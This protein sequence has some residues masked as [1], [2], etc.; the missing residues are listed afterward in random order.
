M[1]PPLSMVATPLGGCQ[2]MW[3]TVD[4][5]NS[6]F[7]QGRLWVGGRWGGGGICRPPWIWKIVT[8]DF[9]HQI[10]LFSYFSPSWKS[11]KI[12]T[13]PPWKKLK[14]RT[15]LYFS[16]ENYGQQKCV[17]FGVCLHF[18]AI[19]NALLLLLFS[20]EDGNFILHLLENI[21]YFIQRHSFWET[22]FKT[23]MPFSR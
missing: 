10:W 17:R 11:V 1:T 21:N 5:E 18:R 6:L 20:S 7:Q 4:A 23:V 14:W 3:T 19:L 2:P 16:A 13:P 9:A 12:L 22:M 15:S 8:C